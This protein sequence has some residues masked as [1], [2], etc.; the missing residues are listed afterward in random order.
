MA[1]DRDALS[2]GD[3]LGRTLVVNV[4][5]HEAARYTT[6]LM[7]RQA[8]FDVVEAADGRSALALAE[9]I[10]DVMVLDVRL[11]DIDGFEVCRQIRSN[12]RT[13][14]IKVLHTSA[15]FVTIEKRVQGL[16][17]GADGYL[18]QPGRRAA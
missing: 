17:M 18:A 4:N 5:D 14:R 10:P 6:T 13:S 3:R 15:T 7:L 2:I 16:Q 8:G 11:P 9:S 12:P 1:S